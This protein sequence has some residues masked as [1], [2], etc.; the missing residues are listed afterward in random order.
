M[1]TGKYEPCKCNNKCS[2]SG[3]LH[4]YIKDYQELLNKLKPNKVIEW[5]SGPNTRMAIDSGAKKVVSI[6]Q[7]PKWNPDFEHENLEV[8]NIP[9]ESEEYVG[10]VLSDEW[11]L[12]FVDSRR[13]QEV[14]ELANK[15]KDVVVCLHDAQRP[16][17]QESLKKYEY[18]HFLNKG[19]CFATNS[20]K[21]YDLLRK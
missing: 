6:E 14:V 21:K 13:R 16:R 18:V 4:S 1:I 8:V 5:G 12:V 9:V 15:I 20:K 11:D 3:G 7:D 10:L 19:F 17:Y 2:C